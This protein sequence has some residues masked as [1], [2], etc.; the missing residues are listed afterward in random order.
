MRVSLHAK[1]SVPARSQ[2]SVPLLVT[3]RPSNLPGGEFEYSTESAILLRLLRKGTDLAEYTL[4][5]FRTELA[6]CN[7]GRLSS[8]NMTDEMLQELGYFID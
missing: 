6:V 8:V 1:S 7:E 3:I 5:R 2:V 4:D